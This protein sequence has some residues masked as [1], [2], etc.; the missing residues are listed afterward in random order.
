V[1]RRSLAKV[2]A[3]PVAA[4]GIAAGFAAA[5][6]SAYAQ[7]ISDTGGSVSITVPLSFVA[8]LAKA[9]IVEFPVPVSDLSVNTSNETATATFTV[10]GGDGNVGLLYGTVD[11]SGSVD[12]VGVHGHLNLVT[13][14][15]LQLDVLNGQFDA[16]PAGSSTP[17]VLLDLKGNTTSV[18]AGTSS[19]TDV[20]DSSDLVVDSAGAAYLDSALGT[21]AFQAGQQ[22]GTLSSSWTVVTSS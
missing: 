21:S 2:L 22:V 20:Y 13:L 8:Q 3:A 4:V 11:L 15:S 6:P 19:S 17:V 9:G 16:T 10:T 5:A 14:G 12:V 18:T 1:H 7:T